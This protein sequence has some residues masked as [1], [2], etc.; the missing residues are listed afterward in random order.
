MNDQALASKA[1][2]PSCREK[3]VSRAVLVLFENISTG[4]GWFAS[5]ARPQFRDIDALFAL[6]DA[7]K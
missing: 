2:S 1:I 6:F 3:E 4:D 7:L 5:G